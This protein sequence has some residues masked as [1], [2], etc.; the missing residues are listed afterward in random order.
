[1][2][3]KIVADEPSAVVVANDWKQLL[4]CCKCVSLICTT[5]TS[6]RKRFIRNSCSLSFQFNEMIQKIQENNLFASVNEIKRG[7]FDDDK[8]TEK[9]NNERNDRKIIREIAVQCEHDWTCKRPF[10]A[11]NVC[12]DDDCALSCSALGPH[13][14]NWTE[15]FL[16]RF[17]L[18]RNATEARMRRLLERMYSHRTLF[19]FVR[20]YHHFN[21]L[22]QCFLSMI[23]YRMYQTNASA[24]A[25]VCVI[26]LQQQTN[27][28]NK[29]ETIYVRFWYPLGPWPYVAVAHPSHTGKWR[30]PW[31]TS[32]FPCCGNATM[33][34]RRRHWFFHCSPAWKHAECAALR[35]RHPSSV[36]RATR[37]WM[38]YNRN[39][40]HC[41][42]NAKKPTVQQRKKSFHSELKC[43]RKKQ[44]NRDEIICA[45][46]CPKNINWR[47][48]KRKK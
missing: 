2:H 5:S 7:P 42:C 30:P 41:T 14:R 3:G 35:P 4:L 47:L 20:T 6:H 40:A 38:W 9:T 22:S 36:V 18:L 34:K 26:W 23:S 28:E 13:H 39:Y 16:F 37:W 24:R 12:D 32:G 19:T 33:S 46:N 8:T 17:E 1:M 15:H 48:K 43:R 44:T 21:Y 25:C 10:D 29:S 31:I 27:K 11:H 45:Q